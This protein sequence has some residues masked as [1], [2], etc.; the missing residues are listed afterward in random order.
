MLAVGLLLSALGGCSSDD[1]TSTRA[2]P[3]AHQDAEAPAAGDDSSHTRVR[4]AARRPVRLLLLGRFHNPTYLA[5]PPGDERRFVVQRR[6]TIVALRGRKRLG[7]FLDVSERVST[8]G[9]GGLLSMAFAP[10]YASSGRFYV[11]YTDK[12]GFLQID[13]FRR[14]GDPDR[15]DPR[16]RRSVIRVPHFRPNH[17]G[18]QLQFGPDGTLYAG[19]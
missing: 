16:S 12:R 10:D 3:G 9:E 5:A 18:G 13:Q 15:A 17:K 14:G 7:T 4:P 1:D 11:Y 19:F 8:A 2:E 6:G